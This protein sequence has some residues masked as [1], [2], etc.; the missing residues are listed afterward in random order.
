MVA[1]PAMAWD[2]K[3]KVAQDDVDALQ[4]TQE[5]LKDAK[6]REAYAKEHPEAQNALDQVKKLGGTEGNSD[7]M[8][9]IS[10]EIMQSI[11]AESGGDVEKMQAMIAQA[12]KNPEAFFNQLSADQKAK[13]RK[14]AGEIEKNN[15]QAK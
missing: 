12:T 1:Q 5:L 7:E 2:T 15:P 11:V 9:S 6:A 14:V 4:K 3:K 13:I 8:F 10:A